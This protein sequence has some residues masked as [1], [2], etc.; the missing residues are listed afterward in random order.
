[1]S[2][3]ALEGM[4]DRYHSDFLNSKDV[5]TEESDSA[6]AAEQSSPKRNH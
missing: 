1:M 6:K 4:R 5:H 2:I 3:S